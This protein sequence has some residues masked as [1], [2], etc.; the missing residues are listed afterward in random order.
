MTESYNLFDRRSPSMEQIDNMLRDENDPKTRSTLLVMQQQINATTGLIRLIDE[1][2][3]KVTHQFGEYERNVKQ[4]QEQLEQ[5]EKIVIKAKTSMAWVTSVV[6][7][8]QTLSIRIGGYT[9]SFL[10][11]MHK[12]VDANALMVPLLEKKVDWLTDRA[13]MT[14]DSLG[15]I[16]NKKVIRASK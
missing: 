13:G 10:A 2:H 7:I 15:K 1:L 9:F 6:G 12:Q 8:L 14:D 11:D 5:H 16:Q 3:A 4:H